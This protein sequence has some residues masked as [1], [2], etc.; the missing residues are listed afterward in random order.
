MLA[1]NPCRCH[2]RAT[3]PVRCGHGPRHDR[4]LERHGASL[5]PR[6][7]GPL[8]GPALARPRGRRGGH[9]DDGAPAAGPA[10]AGR[11]RPGP[12]AP[13]AGAGLPPGRLGSPDVW[14][15]P[16][17]RL[18][19]LAG[20]PA[21]GGAPPLARDHAPRARP[22]GLGGGG[23]RA[24]PRDRGDARR[25]ARARRDQQPRLHGRGAHAGR[26]LPGTEGQLARAAL[27]VAHRRRDGHPSRALR[28]RLCADRCRRAGRADPRERGRGRRGLPAHEA[29]RLGR[30][31]QAEGRQPGPEAD[32]GAGRAPGLAGAP[33]RRRDPGRGPRGGLERDAAG[34]RLGRGP[35][36]RPR[37]R[38][39]AGRLG[40]AR[41]HDG[42]RGHAGSPRS[43]R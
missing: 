25:P 10:R 26:R 5:H 2:L 19:R 37:R 29:G 27:P 14:R 20:R 9:A 36:P 23:G 15:A 4:D 6:A 17:L 11:P 42:G 33:A 39:G 43:I 8:A 38:D 32:R 24:R 41:D 40:A 18:G 30:P 35:A 12:H 34:A 13:R 7:P 22:R 28:A 16:L 3:S 31:V 1:P 21:D